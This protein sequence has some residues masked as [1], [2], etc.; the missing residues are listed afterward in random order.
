M[1][2]E[3]WELFQPVVPSAPSWQTVHQGFAESSAARVRAK[4]HRVLVDEFGVAGELDWSWCA[5]D[6]V[7]VR[8]SKGGLTGPKRVDCGKPGSEIH[9][10][11]DRAGLP[12]F[13][14]VSAAN[15]HDMLGRHR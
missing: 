3:L 5:I 8:S 9:V 14:G 10:L 13:V 6:S 15:T 7:S 4:L 1:P 12:I 11:T 2:D